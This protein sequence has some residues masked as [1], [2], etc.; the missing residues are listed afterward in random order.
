MKTPLDHIKS[1]IANLQEV[2]GLL[3]ESVPINEPM[4]TDVNTLLKE[5]NYRIETMERFSQLTLENL[6]L[7]LKNK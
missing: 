7:T 5:S 2:V 6:K 3:N 4:P 1:T